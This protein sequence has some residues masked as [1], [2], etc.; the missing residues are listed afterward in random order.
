MDLDTNK[1]VREDSKKEIQIK[2]IQKNVKF[3][4][5]PTIHI[6][7]RPTEE[8]KQQEQEWRWEMWLESMKIGP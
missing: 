5:E 6:I 7:P 1:G 2:S 4:L 3:N 8:E